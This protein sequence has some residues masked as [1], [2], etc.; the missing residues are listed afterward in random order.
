M[1]RAPVAPLP[2]QFAPELLPPVRAGEVRGANGTIFPQ[3]YH[4]LRAEYFPRLFSLS[5]TVGCIQWRCDS[6]LRLG[7]EVGAVFSASATRKL[8]ES[9]GGWASGR[10]GPHRTGVPA[11]R[12]TDRPRHLQHFTRDLSARHIQRVI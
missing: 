4:W 3:P 9:G 1:L 10:R 6:C 12:P 11:T 5:A 8:A 7:P 2:T